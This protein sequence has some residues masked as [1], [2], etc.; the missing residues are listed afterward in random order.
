MA[1]S[2]EYRAWVLELLGR[3]APVSGRAMF[4]AVGLYLDGIMFG[5]I[6]D[7]SVYFK[8]DDATRPD[9][10]AAGARPFRPFGDARPM[11]Y[12]ELPA[13]VLEDP[14]PLRSWTERAVGAARR[15]KR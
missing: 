14:D 9:F 4:G 7:G 2:P 13:E 11:P 15:R 1:V 10:E 8:T 12:F 3:V 5:L 6:D